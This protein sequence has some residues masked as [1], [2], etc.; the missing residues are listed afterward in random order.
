MAGGARRT[1]LGRPG[2]EYDRRRPQVHDRTAEASTFLAPGR[3]TDAPP[4]IQGKGIRP[5]AGEPAAPPSPSGA[6]SPLPAGVQSKMERAFG[7]DFS[8]IRVHQDGAAD[9]VGAQAFARG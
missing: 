7:A 1:Q 2:M 6:G 8:A 3:L 5:D 4:P 9:A